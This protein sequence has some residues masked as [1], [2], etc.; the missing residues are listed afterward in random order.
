MKDTGLR[1]AGLIAQEVEAVLPEAVD[2]PEGEKTLDYAAT[3]SLLVNAIKE[4]AEQIEVLKA[5]LEI[6]EN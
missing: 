3:I 2:G 5:R 6:L 4:Q 1:N